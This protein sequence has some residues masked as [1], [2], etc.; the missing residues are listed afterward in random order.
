MTDKT[1]PP[2]EDN[3]PQPPV[4][5][6]ATADK[7]TAESTA[8]ASADTATTKPAAVAK[9]KVSR[10]AGVALLLSLLALAV[11]VATAAYLGLSLQQQRDALQTSRIELAA[12]TQRTDTQAQQVAALQRELDQ[13]RHASS[14]R[15]QSLQQQLER[16]QREQASQQKRLQT[17]TTTDRADWLLAEAEYLISLANQRLLMGKEIAGATD[18]LKAADDIMVELDDAG[19]HA[20]RK[21][22]ANDIA[23]LRAAAQFDLE[24]IYLQL[25]AAAQQ[26]DQLTL[27]AMPELQ[28]A[29]AEPQ[30]PQ[31]WQQQ[32]LA[33]FRAA[34]EKLSDY[35]Q[36]KR[37]DEV[38]K[39]LLAPE[40]ESAVRQ[41]LRLSFEQAQLAALAAK[42]QLYNDSLAKARHWL[43][44][45]YT[46]DKT[47]AQA[48]IATIDSLQQQ[49]I[50][51]DLPDIS[52][53][54][55][56]LKDYLNSIHQVSRPQVVPKS[57]ATKP[58]S[59]TASEADTESS[60]N[61]KASTEQQP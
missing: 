23:K 11:G 32:W 18:L 22:L 51:I 56:A 34:W 43:E 10:L 58:A 27:F 5:A 53:S 16:L 1:P 8:Q 47:A 42:Q 49:Q 54:Q 26:G 31:T 12:A 17:L 38:Y 39:P 40:F 57:T 3:P 14:Q 6:T 46:L 24:G 48:L 25:D 52:G 60:D 19:L 55:R 28:L 29:E 61:R 7:N 20:V 9:P 2:Q 21:A 44:N 30:Q 15:E 45:Y 41:N 50:E 33:S 37:R 36:I 35:I 59:A 4:P 13:Q